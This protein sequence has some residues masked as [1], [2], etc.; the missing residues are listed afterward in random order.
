MKVIA[1][2]HDKVLV[3]HDKLLLAHDKAH[4]L[5]VKV[6]IARAHENWSIPA[7]WFFLG[8]YVVLAGVTWIFYLRP[9]PAESRVPSLAGAAI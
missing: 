7:L 9:A 6:A 2:S 5:L 1:T 8:A 3:A 4:G